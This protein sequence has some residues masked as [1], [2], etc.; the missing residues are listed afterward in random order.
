[1]YP[2]TYLLFLLLIIGYG[3]AST[4]EAFDYEEDSYFTLE[5]AWQERYASR[6]N[7]LFDDS[8]NATGQP[9]L[10]TEQETKTETKFGYRRDQFG[11]IIIEE[12]EA[13]TDYSAGDY[14]DY[15]YSA[16][17]RRFGEHSG[18]WNYYDPYYTNMYWYNYNPYCFGQSVYT[19]YNW[20]G[21]GYSS[22]NQPHSWYNPWYSPWYSPVSAFNP[23]HW[24]NPWFWQSPFSPSWG[25]TSGW[26]G[27]WAG[28]SYYYN[29]YD[30]NSHYIGPRKFNRNENPQGGPLIMSRVAEDNGIKPR[31]RE[32]IRNANTL[33]VRQNENGITP[34]T[35]RS[36][37][38]GGIPDKAPTRANQSVRGAEN[39]PVFQQ[40]PVPVRETPPVRA[41]Q[42]TDPIRQGNNPPVRDVPAHENVPV[43]E[44]PPVRETTPPSRDNSRSRYD[45]S[46]DNGMLKD[47]S[48]VRQNTPPSPP[49]GNQGRRRESFQEGSR[50][51][52]WGQQSRPE[53]YNNIPPRNNNRQPPSQPRMNPSPGSMPSAPA[54][55]NSPAPSRSNQ[56]PR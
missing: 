25:W 17:I 37:V 29:S 18:S 2:R 38:N 27:G 44:N 23:W 50:S 10:K 35:D 13:F 48:P 36:P 12:G 51:P 15:A 47:N 9:G 32:P 52:N 20:W 4:K 39:Q 46:S 45:N 31:T 19:T 6:P 43:R 1:M 26:G 41:N 33:P 53:Q 42:P 3:C 49:A 40:G 54:R 22:W 21:Y 56:R 24:H 28:G 8:L 7:N 16:R 11:N 30:P 34:P 5:Q 55:Q 14:Y